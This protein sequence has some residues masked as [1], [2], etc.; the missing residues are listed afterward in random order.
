MA[1]PG[2]RA[3]FS[4]G[5]VRL[6]QLGL[7]HHGHGG[8]LPPVLQAVLERRRRPGGEHGAPGLRLRPGRRRHCRA[9]PV[10]GAI[11]DRGAAKKRFLVIFALIGDTATASLALVPKGFWLPALSLYTLALIGFSG[12][13]VFYD[14]LLPGVAPENAGCTSSRPWASPWATSATASSFQCP[15][16]RETALF[17]FSS[18]SEAVRVS[19]LT[20][21]IWWL[22]L[23]PAAHALR[24]GAQHR[25]QGRGLRHGQGRS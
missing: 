15:H 7:C 25:G 6:G 19:F 21:G 14:A 11:A 8:L 10:L 12:G 13:N 23:R 24:E 1:A 20:V 18:A 5:P 17:G 22:P 16:G 4:L 9:R 2:K 3:S